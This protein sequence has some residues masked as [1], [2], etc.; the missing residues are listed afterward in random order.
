VDTCQQGLKLLAKDD[1]SKREKYLLLLDIGELEFLLG[2]YELAYYQLGQAYKLCQEVITEKKDDFD[3][4]R[5]IMIERWFFMIEFRDCLKQPGP[6]CRFQEMAATFLLQRDEFAALNYLYGQ[7]RAMLNLG[8]VTRYWALQEHEPARQR[9]MLHEAQKYFQWVLEENS[10]IHQELLIAMARL[11]LA[12]TTY[13]LKEYDQAATALTTYINGYQAGAE[14]RDLLWQ[15]YYFLGKTRQHCRAATG[16]IEAAFKSAIGI[17]ESMRQGIKNVQERISILTT[18]RNQPY[19]DLV[20][21][22]FQENRMDEAVVYTDRSK[23]RVMQE[24]LSADQQLQIKAESLAIP[25]TEKEP[26]PEPASSG[27]II[28]RGSA[29]NQGASQGE[30]A[31]GSLSLDPA[32]QPGNSP[33]FNRYLPPATALLSFSV[34]DQVTLLC[35]V[36]QESTKCLKIADS[37]EGIRQKVSSFVAKIKHGKDHD[38]EDTT[39]REDARV[40]YRLLLQPAEAWF[41]GMSH[42][43]II[44]SKSLNILPFEALIRD[45]DTFLLEKYRISYSYAVAMYVRMRQKPFQ[46]GTTF[47]AIV[48]PDGTLPGTEKEL[49]LLRQSLGPIAWEFPRQN[50]TKDQIQ[51]LDYNIFLIGAHYNYVAS[52]PETSYFVLSK[53]QR[54]RLIDLLDKTIH[55]DLAILNGCQTALGLVG[56]SEEVMSMALPFLS[57]GSSAV[58]VSLLNLPDIKPTTPALMRAFWGYLKQ[59]PYLAG[60]LTNAK[61]DLIHKGRVPYYCFPKTD[62]P[63]YWAG[64]ILI[65]G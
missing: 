16:E 42:L 4:K 14:Y 45:D 31:R 65:G 30:A 23:S 1:R 5:L 7:S 8:E 3:L 18:N 57:G 58:M 29:Q 13:Y 25:P 60:A 52:Q 20:W 37:A 55:T 61:L 6:D 9:G 17:I 2:Q 50:G 44:P 35:I 54:L 51:S 24:I 27:E 12:K 41:A 56:E 63:Y 46:L 48:N 62:H 28:E 19:E 21:F 38:G 43:V 15:A 59:S 36:T 49:N 64:I 10:K 47:G 26:P 22:L 40:L 53:H 39:Y 34:Y 32:T 11:E 33:V